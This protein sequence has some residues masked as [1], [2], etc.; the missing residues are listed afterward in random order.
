M[1]PMTHP[2]IDEAMKKA[3]IAWVAVG[4]G[5]ARMVWCLA[6]DGA[7]WVVS[8]PGE[9]EAPGLATASHARVT[10]RGDHGGRVV[11]WPAAVASVEPGSEQWEQVVPQLAS[12]R[13]N[14]PGT[15]E[16]LI[17]RWAA[18]CTVSRLTPAGEPLEAGATLPD[19]ALSEPPRDTPA[20]RRP[21]SPFRLHR[22][23]RR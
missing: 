23:R 2:L 9:Q 3:A 19:S 20:V 6:A 21:R 17:E 7:L 15:A 5:P 1:A 13:L 16:A 14:A 22:V 12:K 18:E 4:D 11:T 8:G 10:M